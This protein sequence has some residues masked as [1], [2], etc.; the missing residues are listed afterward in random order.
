VRHRFLFAALCSIACATGYGSRGVMFGY[1]D[2]Q[3]GENTFRVSFEGNGLTPL[4]K[5]SDFAL[6]RSAEVTLDHGYPY[7]VIVNATA[8]YDAATV[9]KALRAKYDLGDR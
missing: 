2:T 1:S 4:A 8:V 7:F 6:L 3:V 9:R 5:V